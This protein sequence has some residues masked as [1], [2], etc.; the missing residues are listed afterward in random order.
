[1]AQA[2][3]SRKGGGYS[4]IT[5]NN[6][7][8][9]T[10]STPTALSVG[11]STLAATTVGNYA[12]F[13]GG[14]GGAYQSVVDAYNTSLTRATPTALSVERSYL[15]ATTVGDYALF[16]GGRAGDGTLSPAVDFYYLNNQVQVYPGTK[17]KLGSMTDEAISDSMQ[18]ITTT[19]PIT[20]YIK[21]KNATIN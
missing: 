2:L 6:V 20:G 3:I 18:M 11:R 21:I 15:A 4:T 7:S 17:Y 8:D 1:M 19:V 16:G 14:Y 9:L 13:G 10:R 12:L 5:F